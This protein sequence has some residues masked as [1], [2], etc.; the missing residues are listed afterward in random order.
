MDVIPDKVGALRARL[1]QYYEE[2]NF[3]SSNKLYN[4]LKSDGHNI[5]KKDVEEFLSTKK[6]K[7]LFMHQTKK[8]RGY[9]AALTP[10]ENWQIDI[11]DMTN[12]KKQNKGYGYILACVDVF[13]RRAI[14]IPMKHKTIEETTEALTKMINEWTAPEIIV[15]DNDSS[16]MGKQFQNLINHHNIIHEPNKIGDHHALGIIDRFA[17]TLKTIINTLFIKNKNTNWIDSLDRVVRQYN[18]TPNHGINNYSPDSVNSDEDKQSEIMHL[19]LFKLQKNDTVS[20]L[21]PGDKVRTRVS[22]TFRKGTAPR[23]SDDIFEVKEVKGLTITLTNNKVIK[24][25]ELL[26][27]SPQ[28]HDEQPTE[29]SHKAEPN[30][31]DKATKLKRQQRALKELE[32]FHKAGRWYL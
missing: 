18:K 31:I 1:Q 8:R 28:T 13:T 9:I 14:C 3:P 17:R 25:T 10:N 22:G 4:I 21:Q 2:Y 19:N 26:K 7:Q 23:W 27:V 16:F 29:V 24:R 30:V 6:E 20:D 15:S 11:Y 32:D 5:K 12:Y